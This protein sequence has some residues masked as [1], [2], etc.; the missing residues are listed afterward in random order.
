VRL[1][2]L[3]LYVLLLIDL[4]NPHGYELMKKINELTQGFIRMG[5][6]TM[7]PLLFYLKN[8]KLITEIVE[9]RRKKYVLTDKGREYLLNN[10]IKLRNMVQEIK[11]LIDYELSKYGVETSS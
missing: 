3:K 11:N 5:P 7:Y 6:G 8:Q 4:Y 2:L 10:I 9:G 1:N